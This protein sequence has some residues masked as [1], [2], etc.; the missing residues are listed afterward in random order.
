MP[1]FTSNHAVSTTCSLDS[2]EYQ[3]PCQPIRR[4]RGRQAGFAAGARG[5][6]FPGI[7]RLVMDEPGALKIV[8][9]GRKISSLCGGGQELPIP[10]KGLGRVR[11][12]RLGGLAASRNGTNRQVTKPQEYRSRPFR[13]GGFSRGEVGALFAFTESKNCKPFSR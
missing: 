6:T 7:S 3:D 1:T 4:R 5:C 8:L 13:K 11:P 12:K 10:G 9:Q 2:V